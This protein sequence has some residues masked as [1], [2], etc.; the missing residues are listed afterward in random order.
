MATKLEL[1]TKNQGTPFHPYLN[2]SLKTAFWEGG[3]VPYLV[4]KVFS[5]RQKAPMERESWYY[6]DSGLLEPP[7]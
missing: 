1:A 3:G 7:V 5:G 2:P 6:E 4:I